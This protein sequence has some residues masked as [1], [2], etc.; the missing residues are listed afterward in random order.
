MGANIGPIS[1]R[2]V[3]GHGSHALL[4]ATRLARASKPVVVVGGGPA[5]LFQALYLAKIRKMPV[6][7]I[8]QQSSI[9]GMF[10]SEETP[11]GLVDRGVHILEETGQ[12]D[13]DQLIFECLP[14]GSW[15]VLEGVRKDIA[16]NYFRGRLNTGSLYPDMRRLPK[17]DYARCLE[18]LLLVATQPSLELEDS[19]DLSTYF[20][21]R[22]G[23]HATKCIFKPL[24]E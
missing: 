9:G 24:A 2:M 4:R 20:Q 15:N 7:V 11:W 19:P 21:S 23:V 12:A 14:P 22:F 3:T 5:G 8:E 16:G 10:L 13:L 1:R 18:E 17:G 6:L